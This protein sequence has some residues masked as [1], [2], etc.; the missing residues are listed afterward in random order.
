MVLQI[1]L[2][3]REEK[4]NNPLFHVARDFPTSGRQTTNALSFHTMTFNNF[5]L[6]PPPAYSDTP[7]TRL[8]VTGT[9]QMDGCHKKCRADFHRPLSVEE[10]ERSLSLSAKPRHVLQLLKR[11]KTRLRSGVSRWNLPRDIRGAYALVTKDL[12]NSNPYFCDKKSL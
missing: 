4:K 9:S 12:A 7:K 5:L 2:A 8:R 6:W 1:A 3:L 10:Q 11:Y